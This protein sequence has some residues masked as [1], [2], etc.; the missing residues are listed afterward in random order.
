VGHWST[1][2]V[3]TAR[4]RRA[5]E[6]EAT[7]ATSTCLDGAENDADETTAIDV[8]ERFGELY[9]ITRSEKER[10]WLNHFWQ[11]YA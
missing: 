9:A 3:A 4:C 7:Q 6:V 11:R 1:T 2:P 10:E 5:K 8:L